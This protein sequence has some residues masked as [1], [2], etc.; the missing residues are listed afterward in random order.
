MN[1]RNF[2]RLCSSGAGA[3]LGG[4][5]VL[6]APVTAKSYTRAR[7]LDAGGKP[8]RAAQ[9]TARRNYV[10]FYPFVGTPCFLLNLG[11]PVTGVRV[12]G[13]MG[14]YAWPGGAGPARSI[15]AYSA[16]CSHQLT[17]PTRDISFISFRAGKTGPNK[18]AD[19]IHCCSEHSQY[20]PSQ[21]ARVLG[22]PAP[23]PLAAI[24]LEHDSRT[25]ELHATG[26]LG[27]ETFNEFFRKY[28]FRLAMEH[29]GRAASDNSGN[30][31]VT[32]LD[33]YCRQQVQC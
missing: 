30:C 28:E 14:E 5:T 32:E 17:Y 6:A 7:L 12:P 29:G 21:G 3:A 19:V 27:P 22:G 18:H 4:E 31:R 11:R 2:I 16:I 26:T 8:L 25:D 13:D 33:N 24:M 10:F 20:D 1:R 15:V 9:I 23:R